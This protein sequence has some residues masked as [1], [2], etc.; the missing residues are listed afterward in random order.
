[1]RAIEF[2][3][4]KIA[5]GYVHFYRAD[6]ASCFQSFVELPTISDILGLTEAVVAH[7]VLVPPIAHVATVKGREVVSNERRNERTD[8]RTSERTIRTGNST[9]Q[10]AEKFWE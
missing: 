4:S 6:L 9:R 2:A 3:L 8:E 7:T 5:Q 10:F 1:N